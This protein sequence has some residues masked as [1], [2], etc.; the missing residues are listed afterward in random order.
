MK[1]LPLEKLKKHF[2]HFVPHFYPAFQN[3]KNDISAGVLV[4]LYEDLDWTCILTQRSTQLKD[5]SGEICFPGG[6][7]QKEDT[8]LQNTALREA[9][10][11][12]GMEAKIIGRLS[13]IPLYT[14]EFR[15]EPFVAIAQT[16]LSQLHSNEEVQHI[17]PI[18]LRYIFQQP[19]LEGTSFTY[20]DQ[21]L[22]SPHFQSHHLMKNPPTKQCTYGGTA[23]VLH[24]LLQQIAIVVNQKLPDI[25]EVQWPR[26]LFT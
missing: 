12:I 24:E 14:S 6:K 22:I 10:E 4:C 2:D 21:H 26:T 25:K 3:K 9:M 13:S 23:I 15:L 7:Q 19:Y 20:R 1:H 18:S 5:H 11:E 16:P 17:L 8:S